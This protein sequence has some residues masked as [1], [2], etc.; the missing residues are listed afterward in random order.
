MITTTLLT[1]FSFFSLFFILI[2]I[3]TKSPVLTIAGAVT[4]L[5]TGLATITGGVQEF[6]GT[7]NS[8]STVKYLDAANTSVANITLTTAPN[9]AVRNDYPVIA[10]SLFMIM[11][12]LATVIYGATIKGADK[13]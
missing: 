11:S 12:G 4:F 2:G 7:K 1:L 9:Y 13:G 3:Y 6:D 8:T 5:F 10:W